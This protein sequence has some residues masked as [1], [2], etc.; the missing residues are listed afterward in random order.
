MKQR[1]GTKLGSRIQGGPSGAFAGPS[2]REPLLGPTPPRRAGRSLVGGALF[3][4][5][6]TVDR[7]TDRENE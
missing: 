6:V 3:F 2:A 1:P 5:A 4:F 7:R